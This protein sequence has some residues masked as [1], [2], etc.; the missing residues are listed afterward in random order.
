MYSLLNAIKEAKDYLGNEYFE[1][2]NINYKQVNEKSLLKL[3][4][5]KSD[6]NIEYGDLSSLSDSI[7]DLWVSALI[8][9]SSG[10][11]EAM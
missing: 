10:I 7:C 1:G 2:L 4:K 9:T 3:S 11:F 6:I 5:N 8:D